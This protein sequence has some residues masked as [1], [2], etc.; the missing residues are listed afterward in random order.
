MGQG[1]A[2]N[3]RDRALSLWWYIHLGRSY[4]SLDNSSACGAFRIRRRGIQRSIGAGRG[5]INRQGEQRV[6]VGLRT[7]DVGR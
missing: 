7:V 4:D 1:W 5:R 6:H 2:A 3:S